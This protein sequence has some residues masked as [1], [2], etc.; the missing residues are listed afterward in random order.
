MME[1]DKR[2][3]LNYSVIGPKGIIASFAIE[4][5]ATV[6]AKDLAYE[7][8]LEICVLDHKTNNLKVH[9]CPK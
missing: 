3:T 8:Q 1:P 7:S 5:M 6:I 4:E 9:I 2:L